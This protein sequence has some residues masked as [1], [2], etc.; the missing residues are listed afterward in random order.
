MLSPRACW[1]LALALLPSSGCAVVKPVVLDKKT[2][3][4]NQ[5]LGTFDRL[6]EELVLA[7]SVRSG[8]PRKAL[9]PLEREALDA[10]MSREFN[11]DDLDELKRQQVA[12]EGN[13][14]LLVL[15]APPTEPAALARAKELV[16][17]ENRD[18]TVLLKRALQLGPEL[19]DRDLPLLRRIFHRL[20]VQASQPGERVQEPD[21]RWRTVVGAGGR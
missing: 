11:R 20:N 1:F 10:L 15:L 2:Q 5:I 8:A 16:E 18:R 19:G 12:G 3:L 7:S 14:G 21:G 4:E 17:R 6:E 9:S 13:D